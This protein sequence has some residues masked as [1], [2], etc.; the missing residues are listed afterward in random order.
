M[1][2]IF[3]FNII[4][5]VGVMALFLTIFFF[6]IAVFFEKRI[7]EK[8]VDFIID[9]FIGNTFKPL[10]KTQKEYL[11][12]KIINSINKNDLSQADKQVENQNNS[13]SKKAWTFVGIL[14]GIIVF[15]TITFG[16]ILKWDKYYVKYLFYSAFYS[17]IFVGITETLF[18]FLIAQNY[19]SADPQKIKLNIIDGL[20][21]HTCNPCN[22]NHSQNKDCIGHVWAHCS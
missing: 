17:L 15:I 4:I 18:L 20:Y 10:S 12:D 6:T 19:L 2:S 7:V 21:Q 14:V 1:L 16:F 8:Q 22:K 3:I 9:D 5:H 13:T 11:Q